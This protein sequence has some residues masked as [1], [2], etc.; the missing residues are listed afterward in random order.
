VLYVGWFG[1]RGLASIVFALLMLHDGPAG[2]DLLVDVIALTV[3]LSVV[4]HGGTAAWAARTYAA[5]H[6]MASAADPGLPEGPAETPP[7]PR[8]GQ[9]S[10]V[11]ASLDEVDPRLPR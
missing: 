4:L 5:W 6:A 3:G 8:P 10:S 11:A 7:A 2:T 9:G 1:P